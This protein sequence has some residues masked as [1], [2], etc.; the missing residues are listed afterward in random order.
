MK[1]VLF[2]DTETTWVW[3]ADAIIQICILFGEIDNDWIFYEKVK[4]NQ[5]INSEQPCG[6]IAFS[7]HWITKE[8]ISKFGYMWDYLPKIMACFEEAEY[9]IAHNT[10]FDYRMLMSDIMKFDSKYESE[11][12]RKK[13]ICTMKWSKKYCAIINNGRLKN[14]KLAELHQIL[15]NKWFNNAHDA[16]ADTVACRDCF[17]EL[18]KLGEIKLD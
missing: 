15:F 10:S 3:K 1:K 17:M 8:Q 16:F 18:L 2:F 11:L 14:P 7:I 13:Q 4:I 12:K 5:L 6:Q 9:I